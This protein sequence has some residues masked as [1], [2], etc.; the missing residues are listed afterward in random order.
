[1]RGLSQPR[2]DGTGYSPMEI[3][4]N[5]RNVFV[6]DGGVV[7]KLE[8]HLA[9]RLPEMRPGLRMHQCLVPVEGL[10]SIFRQ[11]GKRSVL[12]CLQ[13][14]FDEIPYFERQRNPIPFGPAAESFVDR[15]FQDDVDARIGCG[16]GI[17]PL[18]CCVQKRV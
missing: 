17:F 1:M 14:F 13:R 12:F 18:K 7:T 16:H 2:L 11:A 9:S 6:G 10:L 4:W 15:L 3:L 5:A 8:G